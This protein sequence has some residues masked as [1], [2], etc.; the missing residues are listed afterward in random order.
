MDFINFEGFLKPQLSL[1]SLIF[2]LA[3][4]GLCFPCEYHLNFTVSLYSFS[5][6][7]M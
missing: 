6:N 4:Y 7:A 3:N 1:G 5:S 2:N